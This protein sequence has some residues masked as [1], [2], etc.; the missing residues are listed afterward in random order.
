V[1]TITFFIENDI[2]REII[3]ANEQRV[4]EL[5]LYLKTYKWINN[6]QDEILY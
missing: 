5:V 6:Y 4:I 2:V 1:R 3:V